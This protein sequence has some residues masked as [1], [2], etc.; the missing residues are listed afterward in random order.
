VPNSP[1]PV[2]E[3]TRAGLTSFLQERRN[4]KEGVVIFDELP[5]RRGGTVPVVAGE[6]LI[7]T[8]DLT[9]Y[10]VSGP[11]RRR[12]PKPECEK[13]L[14]RALTR[15][16]LP[17]S[18]RADLN[19]I[20]TDLI[21]EGLRVTPNAVV[22]LGGG[23]VNVVWKAQSSPE[24]TEKP[25][26]VWTPDLNGQPVK[27]AVIDT[28]I[29]DQQRGDGWLKGLV[30]PDNVDPLD[31]F[32]V[33][34]D[35]L[36]A[37]A[38]HGTFVSGIILRVAPGAD[39]RVY[40]ALDSDGLSSEVDVAEA[41]VTAVKS[42]YQ[43]INLSLGI[44][45]FD[46]LPPMAFT[47]ALEQIAATGKEVVIVAA[48]GNSGLEREVYP[49]ACQG[50]TGVA[51]LTE[52]SAPAA[53]SSRGY[54]VACSTVA[55]NV[56]STYVVGKEDPA[57]D[58]NPEIFKDPS[59]AKWTGTSFAAPQITGEIARIA[60]HKGIGVRAALRELLADKPTAWKYGVI[61]P[62]PLP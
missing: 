45:T 21:D 41:M 36:D 57:I 37:A 38:G 34:D 13:V 59:W 2:D 16:K 56:V 39:L 9:R 20:L 17:A 43:L 46:D 26:P 12:V 30:G 61:V 55:E 23:S 15:I 24:H 8:R 25:Y 53:W 42:G 19:D 31:V 1:K 6:L 11:L 5:D 29:A 3:K 27:V 22:P 51:G 58:P 4:G 54:W 44:E 18:Q 7:R 33:P 49:A 47:V 60:Q 50:V 35:Y 48:A 10:A 32:P 52:T 28:G 14:G 40:R 62:T